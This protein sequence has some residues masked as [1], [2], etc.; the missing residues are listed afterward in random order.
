MLLPRTKRMQASDI[1]EKVRRAVE[2][3]FQQ[4]PGRDR[5]AVTVSLGVATFPEDAQAEFEL[6]RVADQRLYQAKHAGR[7]LVCCS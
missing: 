4:H 7:N 3:H 5:G 2:H 1:A 6:I